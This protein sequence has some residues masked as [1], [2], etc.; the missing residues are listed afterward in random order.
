MSQFAVLV[1]AGGNAVG[2]LQAAE[3]WSL[4]HQWCEDRGIYVGRGRGGAV[5]YAQLP[6]GLMPFWVELRRILLT[7]FAFDPVDFRVQTLAEVAAAGWSF[8]AVEAIALARQEGLNGLLAHAACLRDLM[9]REREKYRPVISQ[10]GE[11][12][13]LRYEALQLMVSLCHKGGD[14]QWVG[15]RLA[16]EP[17]GDVH[18]EHLVP[19]WPLLQ[20]RLLEPVGDL[21][22]N[23][24]VAE[25]AEFR[26]QIGALPGSSLDHRKVLKQFNAVMSVEQ[27]IHR[28]GA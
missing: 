24:W 12:T 9:F 18:L 25:T 20:W 22:H 13:V 17:E 16:V 2:D 6:D 21:G 19:D 3:R 10:Q 7:Q 5:F 23:E 28:S 27:E 8:A 14:S 15:Q 1:N 26:L 11:W 4:V